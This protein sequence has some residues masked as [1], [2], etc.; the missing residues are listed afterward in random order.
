MTSYCSKSRVADR[1]S[2]GFLDAHVALSQRNRQ[3]S[4]LRIRIDAVPPTI[5]Y[6]HVCQWD[7]HWKD[8]SHHHAVPLNAHHVEKRIDW[9]GISKLRN[10]IN[11][12]GA[13]YIPRMNR[14]G[15][16]LLSVAYVALQVHESM[17]GLLQDT[18]ADRA[19]HEPSDTL[20]YSTHHPT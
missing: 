14:W 17:S 18:R 4:V 9:C 19:M 20:F 3:R 8:Y 7:A 10:D 16:R 2:L 13:K 12:N 15:K 1:N 11:S 6:S 5:E